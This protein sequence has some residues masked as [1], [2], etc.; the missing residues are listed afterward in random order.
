MLHG[1]FFRDWV[2]P[3]TFDKN[4]VLETSPHYTDHRFKKPQTV[5]GQEEDGIGYDYSDQLW[6][7][8]YNKAEESAKIANESGAL[9][10]TCLWYEVYLSAYFGRS[11]EIVHII[12]G[13]NVGNGYPYCVFGYRNAA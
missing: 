6:E 1:D 8:D 4:K 2:Y 12:S 11:I 3:A 10:R 13:V 7:W 5:F 9:P